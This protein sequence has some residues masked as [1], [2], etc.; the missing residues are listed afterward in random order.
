[1][2]SIF[3]DNKAANDS[4]QKTT[5][6]GSKLASALGNGIKTAAKVGTALAS[7][8]LAGGTS[9]LAIANKSAATTDRIDKMSQ[10]L[11]LSREGFQKWEYVLSQNGVEIENLKGGM[12]K[13]TNTLD[14]A[15]IGSKT[16]V[17]S[18]KRIGISVKDLKD[19][20]P[21]QVFEKTVEALQKMPAGA[22]KAALANELLGKSGSELMPLLNG[23]AESVEQLKKQAEEMGLVLDNET[24][25]AGVKFTDT[26]DNVKRTLGAVVAK[27][28]GQVMPVV[29]KF[30]DW[31]MANMPTIQAVMGKVFE[32]I[33][34]FVQKAVEIFNNYFLP[35]IKNVV[36]W[37]VANWGSISDTMSSVFSTLWGIISPIVDLFTSFVGY[38]MN[39]QDATNLTIPILAGLT[40]GFIAFKAAILIGSIIST[41][42]AGITALTAATQGQSIAQAILNAVMNANP[43]VLIATLIAGLVAAGVALWR[44][45]DTVV[46]KAKE[47]MSKIAEVWNSIKAKVVEVWT[48]IQTTIS[49]VWNNIKS[50][51]SSAINSVSSTVSSI[52]NGL[53]STVSSIW[54]GIKSA[55]SSPIEA[56]YGVVKSAIDRIKGVFNF[57][58]KWPHIPLPHFSIS[59]SANP[60][61]WLS[62]GVPRL[63]VKWY[64]KGGI[65]DKPTLFSTPYGLKGVGEAGP[66]AVTPISKLQ[67]MID[68]N[69]GNEIVAEKLDILIELLV[70]FFP[71]LFNKLRTK[72]YLNNGVLVGELGP[73]IDEYFGKLNRDRERGR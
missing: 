56:A 63:S 18:F 16:A 41:V 33:G 2:G 9:L 39:F 17:E 30:L 11:N 37:V 15:K 3:V 34:I 45:W 36:N 67:E 48:G 40:A 72:I 25:D 53:K 13:L 54:N 12:K 68:W 70:G 62:E 14:D 69:N 26:M 55:I 32:Y 38:L 29:Q 51:V 1:M 66:E 59:G 60:L 20:T 43:F 7:M 71:E 61:K 35:V 8:A 21:E 42:T 57:K 44:N 49:N 5:G 10:K 23:T 73:E 4:I 19:L 47:L 52:F 46:A 50:S 28:G 22:E 31:I 64:A 24:I 6:L 58:F 65:F 27:I